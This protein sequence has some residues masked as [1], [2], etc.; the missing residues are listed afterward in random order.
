MMYEFAAGFQEFC[1]K[2]TISDI[3]STDLF[4]GEED[5]V[6]GERERRMMS[7]TARSN[8]THLFL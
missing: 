4:E 1:A 2:N 6:N 3:K 8:L 7:E 5:K